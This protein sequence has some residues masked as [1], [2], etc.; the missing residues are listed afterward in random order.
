MSYLDHV[1]FSQYLLEILLVKLFLHFFAV[2]ICIITFR[3]YA[4]TYP[5]LSELIKITGIL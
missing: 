5:V 4:N 2:K 1:P 3:L